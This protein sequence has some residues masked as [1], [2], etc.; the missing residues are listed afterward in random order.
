VLV[1]LGRRDE[2]GETARRAPGLAAAVDNPRVEAVEA[3]ESTSS[4][5]IRIYPTGTS[6][7]TTVRVAVRRVDERGLVT[8]CAHAHRRDLTAS[9]VAS[10]SEST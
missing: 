10:A 4:T 7:F 6:N 2:A 9:S 5:V 8:P 3:Y 1:A